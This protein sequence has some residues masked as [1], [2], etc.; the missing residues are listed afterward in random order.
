MSCAALTSADEP[1]AVSG[2]GLG[3]NLTLLYFSSGISSSSCTP[4]CGR[5]FQNCIFAVLIPHGRRETFST[6]SNRTTLQPPRLV[7]GLRRSTISHEHIRDRRWLSC[8]VTEFP[9]SKC[10]KI[11]WARVAMTVDARTYSSCTSF[12]LFC[13]RVSDRG[14]RESKTVFPYPQDPIL[15]FQYPQKWFVGANDSLPIL[16]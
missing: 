3:A 7:I 2:P 6:P 16:L 11:V 9:E 8:P 14:F 1:L 12:D 13:L 10:I 5:P 4:P 15:G